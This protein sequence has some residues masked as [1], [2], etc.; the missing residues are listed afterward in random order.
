[1]NSLAPSTRAPSPTS[2][3]FSG[4]SNYRGQ[5]APPLPGIDPRGVARAHFIELGIYLAD[6]LSKGML[7]LYAIY[8]QNL[9]QLARLIRTHRA[10]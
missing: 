9:N 8:L 10:T 2:T 7:T 6:Y 4:I 3:V 1:M 5:N